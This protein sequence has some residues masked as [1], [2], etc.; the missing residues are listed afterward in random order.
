M[1]L[2]GRPGCAPAAPRPVLLPGRS[3]AAASHRPVGLR[4]RTVRSATTHLYLYAPDG[5]GRSRLA[6]ALAKPRVT[7]GLIATTRNWNT[8]TKLVELTGA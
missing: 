1:P 7:K 2:P 3:T 4:A 8:V 5:L 6:E